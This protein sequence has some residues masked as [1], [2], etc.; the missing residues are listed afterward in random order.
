MHLLYKYFVSYAHAKGFGNAE[1]LMNYRLID[2]GSI[3]QLQDNIAITENLDKLI[4]IGWRLIG[5]KLKF[6]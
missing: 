6:K 4:I 3:R 1:C 5:I 2:I